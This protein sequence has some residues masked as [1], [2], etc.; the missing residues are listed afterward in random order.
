MVRGLLLAAGTTP[1]NPKAE[2]E[3]FDEGL[4][5]ANGIVLLYEVVERSRQ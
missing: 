3:L 1:V 5:D 4:N 2:I